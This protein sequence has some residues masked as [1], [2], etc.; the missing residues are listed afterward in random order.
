MKLTKDRLHLLTGFISLGFGIYCLIIAIGMAVLGL[1]DMNLFLLITCI[2][3]S[4]IYTIFGIFILLSNPDRVVSFIGIAF[5]VTLWLPSGFEWIVW[6]MIIMPFV[7]LAR[8]A[9]PAAPLVP[10]D[11]E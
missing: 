9:A 7:I 10:S 6:P 11:V 8:G 2:I 4:I 3:F 1:W 5:I